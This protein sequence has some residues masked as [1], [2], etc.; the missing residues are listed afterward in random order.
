MYDFVT[1]ATY[2]EVCMTCSHSQ[3]L[4]T[5]RYYQMLQCQE[6][7]RPT[8][9]WAYSKYPPETESTCGL[10]LR[11]W[12]TLTTNVQVG[13]LCCNQSVFFLLIRGELLQLRKKEALM[14]AVFTV[15][16]FNFN[17]LYIQRFYQLHFETPQQIRG[18]IQ[19]E[20]DTIHDI[21][22]DTSTITGVPRV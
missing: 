10:L 4:I 20:A 1:N 14:A 11:S 22:E 19:M 17:S 7:P 21:K 16:S 3:I 12:K 2:L 6:L 5:R 15:N 18:H 13:Q 8:E 9:L